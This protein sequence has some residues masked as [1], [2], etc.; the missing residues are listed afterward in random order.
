MKH[1][2]T[3]IRIVAALAVIAA[4]LVVGTKA[5]AFEARDQGN[6]EVLVEWQRQPD[7]LSYRVERTA[8]G[9]PTYMFDV[10]DHTNFMDVAG[11]APSYNY[12]LLARGADG[13]ER[14]LGSIQ[15]SSP[16]ELLA[17]VAA[18]AGLRPQLRSALGTNLAGVSDSSSELPFVDVMKSSTAWISGDTGGRWD[19]GQPLYLDD[20]GWPRSLA[21]GQIARKLMLREIGG[22]YPAGQYLVRYKGQGTVNFQGATLVSQQPGQ[23]IIQMNPGNEGFYLEIAATNPDDHIRDI[24]VIMPG[25]VCEGNLYAY[26]PSADSCG[27][28]R[29]LSFA[30]YSNAIIFYPVF[31]DRLR[32]YSVLRF[33]DWMATNGSNVTSW[34]QH[35]P[36]TYHTWGGPNGVPPE[37]MIA[38][39][40]R[41][42]AHP[43]FNMP[44]QT[45]DSYPLELAELAKAR[46]APTLGVYVEYSN[47][48]WNAMFAQYAHAV[49]GG[50]QV[51]L[52]NMQYYAVRADSMAK[53]FKNSLGASRVVGVYGAQT[54]NT[55]TAL[56]GL[57]YLVSVHGNPDAID[58]IAIAP[59]FAVM[60][61]PTQADQVAGMGLNA[62]FDYVRTQ[63]IPATA[64]DMPTY[65]GIAN[66]YRLRLIT[67]EGGQHM[68]GVLGAQNNDA[69]SAL[70]DAFNR[71]PRIDA[72]YSTYLSE[73][74][75]AAGQ[76]F[77]HFNDVGIFSKWGRWGS[78]E[79]VGQPR[80]DA[81]KFDALQTFIEQNPLWWSQ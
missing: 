74:K 46:L 24:E 73:W 76:L 33:M 21:P 48:V 50:A 70:F 23:L 10:G 20:N 40:N 4:A 18:V 3:T 8:A 44:H 54:A 14:D 12:R 11:L 58:A 81:P 56:H 16:P 39:A 29:F 77:V 25:G 31:A 47:E 2:F 60:P 27:G 64:T 43:W 52:D 80:A 65:S 38:L 57:D 17:T 19:N 28:A 53:I 7:A 15:Y 78:L 55:W 22:N 35:T 36:S 63:L 68:V 59:Y 72:L 51:G 79:Y 45:D 9:L 30:D 62:F 34:A 49:N 42:G 1:A 37:I 41:I 75:Q 13:V 61:D 69:L 71:D 6:G 26:A 67:Y 32:S 66:R 5:Y